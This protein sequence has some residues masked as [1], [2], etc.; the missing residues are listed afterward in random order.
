ML[1]I[2]LLIGVICALI[3]ISISLLYYFRNKG[4]VKRVR[5]NKRKKVEKKKNLIPRM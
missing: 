1:N 5:I 4:N 2:S 3:T